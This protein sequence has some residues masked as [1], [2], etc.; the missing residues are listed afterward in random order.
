MAGTIR[1]SQRQLPPSQIN[2]DQASFELMAS[3]VASAE[4]RVNANEKDGHFWSDG[5]HWLPSRTDR[6]N[7]AFAFPILDL[8]ESGEISAHTFRAMGR[9]PF[10]RIPRHD[11][12]NAKRPLID[13]GSFGPF[14]LLAVANRPRQLLPRRLLLVQFAA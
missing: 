3:S 6:E 12:L 8:R 10:H 9:Q 1:Q 13:N 5:S 7:R 4:G 11:P 2:P 14:V